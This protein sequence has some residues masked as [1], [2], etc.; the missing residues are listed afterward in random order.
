MA[1]TK[2]ICL[3][4]LNT[5]K[6]LLKKL[7]KPLSGEPVFDITEK[8]FWFNLFMWNRSARESL[9]FSAT[10]PEVGFYSSLFVNI[11]LVFTIQAFNVYSLSLCSIQFTHD[12]HANCLKCIIQ[13]SGAPRQLKVSSQG[14]SVSSND[15]YFCN[16]NVCGDETVVRQMSWRRNRLCLPKAIWSWATNSVPGPPVHL[17]TWGLDQS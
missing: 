17:G 14:S 16:Y 1:W 4:T 8:Q 9:N 12:R 7:A 3:E 6:T 5:G 11:P 15:Q 13:F 10:L 2:T